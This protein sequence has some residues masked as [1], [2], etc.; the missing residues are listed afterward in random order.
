[1]FGCVSS[2]FAYWFISL[3]FRFTCNFWRPDKGGWMQFWNVHEILRQS[4]LI[5]ERDGHGCSKE[6]HHGLRNARA[7]LYRMTFFFPELKDENGKLF[8]LLFRNRN[9]P[10]LSQTS[11][12]ILLPKLG[13]GL[14]V[15]RLYF[16][17]CCSVTK[18][19]PTLW[20]LMNCSTPGFPVLH[21][22]PEFAQTH[23]YW[24]SDAIKLSHPLFPLLLLPSVFPS[25][26]VFSNELALPIRWLKYWS[27]NFSISPSNE[28]SGLISFRIDW[29]DLL[30]VQGA[31]N[32]L[33]QHHSL[34]HQFF[35]TQSSLQSNS[36]I[37]T[38]LLEKP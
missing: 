16:L 3:N 12:L 19:C 10:Y 1:M 34:K 15:L 28:Y 30:A 8:L 35:S 17:C 7:S 14:F 31:L 32:S 13:N 18:L 36:H 27:F 9:S 38:W 11:P 22:L 24:V 23:V 6:S 29:L 33:L 20:D 26:R 37:H 2:K 5:G 21:Y 4:E 25:I